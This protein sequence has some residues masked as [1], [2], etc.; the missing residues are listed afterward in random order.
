M[1]EGEATELLKDARRGFTRARIRAAARAV[2]AEHGLDGATMEQIAQAAGTRR[3]TVYNHFRDK[4]EILGE[5]AR[6]FGE[7]VVAVI[8]H[9]PMGPAPRAELEGWV[10]EIAALTVREKAPTILLL[11]LGMAM[12]APEAVHDFGARMMRAMAERQP[13]FRRAV[14]PGPE[15]GLVRARASVVLRQIGFACSAFIQGDPSANDMIIVAAELLERFIE[16]HQ[17]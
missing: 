6:E 15:Q 7:Q 5:I 16:D 4:D 9:L 14:E 10:R 17:T 8:G 1:L 12:E 11:Q 2:F 3:S 13:A